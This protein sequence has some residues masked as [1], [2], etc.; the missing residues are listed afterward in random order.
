MKIIFL[1]IGL[2]VNQFVYAKDVGLVAYLNEKTNGIETLDI[3]L[4]DKLIEKGFC[5]EIKGARFARLSHGTINSPLVRPW[6]SGCWVSINKEKIRIKIRSFE[7]NEPPLDSEISISLLKKGDAYRESYFEVK[8]QV[9]VSAECKQLYQARVFNYFLENICQFSGG[10][11]ETLGAAAHKVCD[12][13]MSES[14]R[15]VLSNEVKT[16]IGSDIESIGQG[17]FCERNKEGYFSLVR[18][19]Y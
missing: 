18:S 2:L 17:E 16:E 7:G 8:S 1:L 10:V 4:Y 19:K 9:A 14:E 13:Q 5:S 15:E 11:S 3:Q 6:G 12:G